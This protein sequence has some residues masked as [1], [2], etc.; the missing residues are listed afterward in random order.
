MAKTRKNAM[1]IKNLKIRSKLSLLVL[2]LLLALGALSIDKVWMDWN[3]KNE[4]ALSAAV[5]N[6]VAALGQL[7][8]ELQSERGMSAGFLASG[9]SEATTTA[10]KAQRIKSDALLAQAT[11]TVTHL[12]NVASPGA[13]V[14]PAD[15]GLAALRQ[16]LTAKRQ[17]IDA[18]ALAGGAAIQWYSGRISAIIDTIDS[19]VGDAPSVDFAQRIRAYSYLI[20]FKEYAGRERAGVN[21]T[22]TANKPMTTDALA[23]LIGNIA[24]QENFEKLYRQTASAADVQSLTQA[25]DKPGVKEALALRIEVLKKAAEGDYD[26]APAVWWT[27]ISEKMNILK[28]Q[29]DQLTQKLSEL[30]NELSNKAAYSF[31]LASVLST[32]FALI[33]LFLTYWITRSIEKPLLSLQSSMNSIAANFDLSHRVQ[34]DGSDEIA[35]TSASFNRMLQVISDALVEVNTTMESL[36]EGDFSKPV[37]ASLQGDMAKLK[38]AVNTS[39]ARVEGTIATLNQVTHALQ[40]GNFSYAVDVNAQGEYG[41]AMHNAQRAMSSLNVML[42]DI[43]QVMRQM[44]NG[45]LSLRIEATGQGDLLTLRDNINSSLDALAKTMHEININTHQLALASRETSEAISQIA[46]GA[47]NQ[48]MAISQ[49]TAAVRQSSQAIDEVSSST[50]MASGKSRESVAR[51]QAGVEKMAAMVEVVTAIANNSEK[52]SKITSVIEKIANKTNLLS[53]NAA[54]EAARAGEHGK[55]FAVVADEVGKLA[56]SSAAS[57]QEIAQLVQAAS[58]ETAKAVL[59]VTEVSQDMAQ[60]G[61]IS[62]MTDSLL[63]RISASLEEQ[64]T[65]IDEIN[66][67]LTGL[68]RIANSNAA[69]SEEMTASVISL[70]NSADATRREVARFKLKA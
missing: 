56:V 30:A 46:D 31:A 35:L 33:F 28:A 17:E 57:S 41:K 68:D 16:A 11:Q 65:A 61:E 9:G 7:V 10:L 66:V 8:H 64:A 34:V 25:L 18:K 47:Q 48:T 52:I 43:G 27:A 63:Q 15:Q 29:D 58:S 20:S 39:L 67:N 21:A 5:V 49:V 19:A 22:V 54:I 60:V 26:I 62:Q 36:A 3:E 45:D 69:A 32:L 12:K 23:Q 44:A 2:P 40:S 37:K 4:Y 6:E 1:N 55:G 13:T 51:V 59:A 14:H 42:S 24:R 38:S 70:S 50:E 53:L